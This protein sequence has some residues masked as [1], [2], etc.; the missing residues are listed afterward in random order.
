VTDP[1]RLDEWNALPDWC[2]IAACDNPDD[3]QRG[4]VMLRDGSIHK[5]CTEHWEAVFRI[6]G[7]QATGE[8]TDGSRQDALGYDLALIP[9]EDTDV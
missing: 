9:R 4:P 8:R 3:D 7:E 6:L 5:L 1:W 2:A